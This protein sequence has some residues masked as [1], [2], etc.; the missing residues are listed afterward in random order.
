MLSLPLSSLTVDTFDRGVH[1]IFVWINAPRC[2]FPGAFSSR[3]GAPLAASPS[4]VCP[5]PA[6]RTLQLTVRSGARSKISEGSPGSRSFRARRRLLAY[7]ARCFSIR[8]RSGPLAMAFSPLF[9]RACALSLILG[10]CGRAR[11]RGAFTRRSFPRRTRSARR[12]CGG[13][14]PSCPRP[15]SRWYWRRPER[16]RARWSAGSPDARPVPRPG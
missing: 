13:N 4:V 6:R 9:W 7:L 3:R 12:Q 8:T 1:E 11:G 16:S 15:Q 2:V 14:V 5:A 10:R